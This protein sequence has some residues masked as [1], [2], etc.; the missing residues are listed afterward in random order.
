MNTTELFEQAKQIAT[1]ASL[2][3]SDKNE[4][5]DE[6]RDIAAMCVN[7]LHKLAE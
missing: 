5:P 4:F 3:D 2:L 6:A 7:N 1:T